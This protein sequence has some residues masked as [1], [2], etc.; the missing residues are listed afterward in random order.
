MVFMS[1]LPEWHH[2]GLGRALMKYSF[3]LARELKDGH[4]LEGMDV[5]LISKYPQAVT[6]IF[7]SKFTQKIAHTE[8]FKTVFKKPYSEFSYEGKT[9]NQRIDPVHEGVEILIKLI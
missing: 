6:G 1:T 7:S 5:K 3:N 4:V 9:Y 8:G 2:K